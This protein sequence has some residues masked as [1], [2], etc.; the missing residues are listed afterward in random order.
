MA[1]RQTRKTVILCKIESSYG[2]DPTPDAADNAIL[3]SNQSVNALNAQNV[4]REN[5]RS[6]FGANEEL[7]GSAYKEVSFDVEL[8]GSG[9]LGV[10]PAWGPLL[11]AAGFAEAI[12]ASTRVDY[13]PVTDSLES[14]TIYYYDDGV[15]HK[16]LGARGSFE[17]LAEVSQRPILRF[18]FLGID[19]GDTA[20]SNPSETL[21]P[22]KTPLVITDA[23]TGDLTFGGTYSA[24]AISGGTAYPSRGI[25]LQSGNSVNFTALVGG[26][27]IDLSGR[28]ISGHVDLDLTAA[29]EVS[30]MADVKANTLSSLSMLHGLND[31]FKVLLFMPA[32]Q[33]INPSKQEVNGKRLIGYD[34]RVT[35]LVGNDELRIVA[36]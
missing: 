20:A 25:T 24:G 28:D 34:L 6:F 15:L 35:P 16:L 1:N 3:V 26:E 19:G 31:G 32:V 18:S 5:V 12:T 9:S 2:V 14:A 7:V 4:N 23:N 33:K 13:T 22:W 27:T 8:Q 30:F 10:A 17:L 29:Q 11:R 36:L 21:T